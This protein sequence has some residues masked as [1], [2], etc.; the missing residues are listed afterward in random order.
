METAI[1]V[2]SPLPPPGSARLGSRVGRRL[3]D[4][5]Q[6][7]AAGRRPRLGLVGQPACGPPFVFDAAASEGID[8]IC[9]TAPGEQAPVGR[10]AVRGSI[11]VDLFGAPGRA[12][13]RLAAAAPGLGLDGLVTLRE[14]AVVW[15][16]RAAERLGLPGLAPA[17]ARAA[18]DKAA[19]RDRFAAAGLNRP[20][21]RVLGPAVSAVMPDRMGFPVV[22][23]PAVGSASRGVLRVDD[24][25]GLGAAV[26]RVRALGPSGGAV[27]VEGYVDGPELVVEAFAVAGRT[28]V[29]AIGAKGRVDGPTFEEIGYLVP[30]PLSPAV[31]AAVVA[32]VAG[33]MAALGLTD[34]PA[35]CELR[36][37]AGRVPV[38]LEIGARLGGG[39]ITAFTVE[40]ATGVCPARMTLRRALGLA[41]A[42]AV[43]PGATGGLPRRL[44]ARAAAGV[45]SIPLGGHGQLDRLDGIGA[46]RAHPETRHLLTFLEPGALVRPYPEGGAYLGFVLSRHDSVMAGQAYQQWLDQTLIAR[47]SPA[48]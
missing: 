24:P 13:D 44:P 10:P 19:M 6:R 39:G 45:W 1:S 33:G 36:L 27:L 41:P 35:H 48:A 34:G 37:A 43:G 28:C 3:D 15:T 18:C 8:L 46:V 14:E 21:H 25:A 22:V 38:L 9:L 4:S 7:A 16:A 20:P 17:A 11:C 40:A 32:E 5:G 31:E 30:A 42:P 26:A 29:L 47:W 23:K 12:L 2:L